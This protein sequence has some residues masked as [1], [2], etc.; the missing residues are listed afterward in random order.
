MLTQVED[1]YLYIASE[2]GLA[3]NT[4][5]AYKYDIERFV[6]FLLQSNIKDLKKVE[7]KHFLSFLD[8]CQKKGYASSSISRLLM[9]LKVF[10]R[11]L[12]REGHID[13]NISHYLSSPK[14]WQVVPEVLSP[15]SVEKLLNAPNVSMELEARDK[16]IIEILYGSGLR[17]SEV[18]NLK[19]NDV[20]DD[21]IRVKGKGGKE[22]IV[23]IGKK[24]I[25]A[26]DHYLCQFDQE[27]K[28]IPYLFLSRSGKQVD[29]VLI[30]KR[31]K[32]YAKRACISQS[33]SPHT[34]RHSFATHLLEN[35]ADL[36]IIQEMLGHA[37]IA[38]TD[39]YTQ[40]SQ[41]HLKNA[42][43]NFHPRL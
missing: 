22:R 25:E 37:N 2:K 3:K 41:K 19:I 20:D 34:L 24:A 31:M 26:I 40:V 11:F 5:E 35:G 4:Q 6:T 43:K 28:K 8:Q 27:R 23:P 10:F 16:A 29:R 18:C 12:K 14:I 9:A 30:W 17:V 15:Q 32:F 42:F 33:L 7:Q 36:R 13:S 39:R 1:F 38:T 21:F